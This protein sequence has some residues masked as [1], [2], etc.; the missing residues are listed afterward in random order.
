MGIAEAWRPVSLSLGSL[1]ELVSH[2]WWGWRTGTELGP[3]F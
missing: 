1:R 2:G 3:P